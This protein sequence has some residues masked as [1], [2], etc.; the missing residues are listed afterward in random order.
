MIA[1][2]FEA[3]VTDVRREANDVKSFELAFSF[4]HERAA[5]AAG[6][7]IDVYLPTGLVRSYS[8]VDWSE[9]SYRIAVARD[10]K[11]RGASEWIHKEITV[12][13]K[14]VISE[15]RNNFAL[16]E[17]AAETL[18][19]AGGIGITPILAMTRRL[20]QLKRSW[21]LY[22]CGRT[23]SSMA[24]SEELKKMRG[25][26]VVHADDVDGGQADLASIISDATAETH[27][28]CCGPTPMLQEFER[29]TERLARD[30]VHVEYFAAARP[31]DTAGCVT[32]TLARQDKVIAVP[33]GKTILDA[34]LDSGIDAP[35]SCM[36][37]HCGTCETA[38]LGGV[39]DHRDVFLSAEQKAKN[40]RIMI[41][42]S[43][44]LT[45][46]LTLDL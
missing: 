21:R 38:V 13:T 37:G 45:P 42:V 10:K 8:V 30:K 41:C 5:L 12:G 9:H 46:T 2:K 28:Y 40:D 17:D 23:A 22:Y 32:I 3:E 1:Q 36:E 19:I 11:S 15:P 44:A 35:C 29:Q 24:F 43:G 7:H 18:L 31:A 34:I 4:P 6:A 26:V 27:L 14:L 25:T 33:P 16:V 20:D 39:P